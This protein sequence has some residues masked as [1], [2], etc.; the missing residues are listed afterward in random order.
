MSAIREA[1]SM[2]NAQLNNCIFRSEDEDWIEI[3]LWDKESNTLNIV[4]WELYEN[5]NRVKNIVYGEGMLD[6]S[7]WIV[8]SDVRIG[9]FPVFGLKTK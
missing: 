3:F 7:A 1:L 9:K 8:E 6:I 2:S 5:V 4:E